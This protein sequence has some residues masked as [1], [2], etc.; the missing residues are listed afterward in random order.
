MFVYTSPLLQGILFVKK[1][2]SKAVVYY[3][4]DGDCTLVLCLLRN[5]RQ[6]GGEVF[7]KLSFYYNSPRSHGPSAAFSPLPLCYV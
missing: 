1:T 2:W 7:I 5:G 3:L 6:R 4:E